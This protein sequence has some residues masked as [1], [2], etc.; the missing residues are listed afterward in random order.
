MQVRELIWAFPPKRGAD[1]LTSWWLDLGT[2]PVLIDCPEITTEFLAQLKVLSKGRKASILLTSKYSHENARKLHE[3][4]GWP[5]LVQE[6]EA[7]LL[8]GLKGLKSFGEEYRTNSGLELLWTPGPTPGS[9]VVYAPAPLNVLFCGRLLIPVSTSKLAPLGKSK[10][11]HWTTQE[12]SLSKL[13]E[14]LPS[15]ALPLLASG[16]GFY[17]LGKDKLL[18]WDAW[19]PL[20]KS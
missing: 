5:L 11:F 16:L 12:R 1:D 13:R 18:Q 10:T 4:L 14:W 3:A 19:E 9:C 7:Y 8:P 6:Q 2:G 17:S 15:D 20:A